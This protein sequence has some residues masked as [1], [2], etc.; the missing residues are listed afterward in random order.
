MRTRFSSK[1][2][3]VTAGFVFCA[4]F[5]RQRWI[6][7]IRSFVSWHSVARLLKPLGNPIDIVGNFSPKVAFANRD[8]AAG[9]LSGQFPQCT[10]EPNHRPDEAVT[11]SY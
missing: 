7:D 9:L 11:E 2:V 6:I 10:S 8:W 3:I 1:G 5:V 4:D